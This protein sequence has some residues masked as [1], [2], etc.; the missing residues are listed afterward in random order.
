MARLNRYELYEGDGEVIREETV[1]KTMAQTAQAIVR[2]VRMQE[3]AMVQAPVTIMAQIPAISA[4]ML[5]DRM[6][7]LPIMVFGRSMR[8]RTD[9]ITNTDSRIILQYGSAH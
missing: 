9:I 3:T 8:L 6:M 1:T 4:R 7:F 2:M 5:P